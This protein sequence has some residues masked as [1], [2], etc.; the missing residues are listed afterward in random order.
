MMHFQWCKEKL[1]KTRELTVC[2]EKLQFVLDSIVGQLAM[3]V[4]VT[5]G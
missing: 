3:V 5:L 4:L 1:S 2:E